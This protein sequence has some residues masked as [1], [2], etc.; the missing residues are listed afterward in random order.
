MAESD[1]ERLERIKRETFYGVGSAQGVYVTRRGKPL[2]MVV[3]LADLDW[4]I[5]VAT[6]TLAPE[7]ASASR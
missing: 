5:E 7:A 1:T 4:L 6:R 3:K 2:Q